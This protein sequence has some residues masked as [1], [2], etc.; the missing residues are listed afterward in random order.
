MAIIWTKK[1]IRVSASKKPKAIPQTMFWHLFKFKNIFCQ[2]YKA[3]SKKMNSRI[4]FFL[5]FS[6]YV[7]FC[8][9]NQLTIELS[10]FILFSRMYVVHLKNN[11]YLRKLTW[12]I[13]CFHVVGI[14]NQLGLQ[15]LCKQLKLSEQLLSEHPYPQIPVGIC[16]ALSALLQ[17]KAGTMM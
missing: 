16:A 17:G 7:K 6:C 10:H 5:S 8:G 9:F 12:Q 14:S 11:R 1:G 15:G 4:I 2:E 3:G 13:I